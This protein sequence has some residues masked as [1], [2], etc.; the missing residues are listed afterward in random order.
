M[1]SQQQELERV[2]QIKYKYEHALLKLANVVGVG[3]GLKV[4]DGHVTETLSVVTDVTEKK[5]LAELAPRDVV[6]VQLE[7]VLT[8][9]Q[10]VGHIK[11]LHEL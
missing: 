8:D 2:Q 11:A 6:P 10:E 4:V 7:G 9:V 3:V 1:T 5:P